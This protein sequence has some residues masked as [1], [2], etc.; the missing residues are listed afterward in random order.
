MM[1]GGLS[2]P[3]R[4]SSACVLAAPQ[5]AASILYRHTSWDKEYRHAIG[6]YPLYT[7]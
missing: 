3:R 6:S 7:Y 1:H 5:E 2:F 4:R